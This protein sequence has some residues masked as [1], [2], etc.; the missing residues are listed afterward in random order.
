M[1][2]I[3]SSAEKL[4][5]DD[6]ID[7]D[8][9]CLSTTP[10]ADKEN[11]DDNNTFHFYFNYAQRRHRGDVDDVVLEVGS[12]R[13]DDNITNTLLNVR[14][15][16]SEIYPKSSVDNDDD[17]DDNHD[18]DHDHNHHHNDDDDDDD[19]DDHDHNHDHHHNDD[20]FF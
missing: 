4:V 20:D 10:S 1:T 3:S 13:H 8:G 14:T 18:D 7:D 2:S 6:R 17:D 15:D 9:F 11:D 5:L 16:G 12:R 19:D